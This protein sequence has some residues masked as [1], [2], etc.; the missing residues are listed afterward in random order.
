[1]E[2]CLGAFVGGALAG[3]LM[4]FAVF[5]GLTIGGLAIQ[6]LVFLLQGGAAGPVLLSTICFGAL[7]QVGYL[8]GTLLWSLVILKA[9]RGAESGHNAC[10]IAKSIR[11]RH[12]RT[13]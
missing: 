12:S 2:A 10:V 3:C 5:L 11:I 9:H 13:D 1:M 7:A 4:R 8:L 6:A